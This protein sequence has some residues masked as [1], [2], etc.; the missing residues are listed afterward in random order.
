MLYLLICILVGVMT[1]QMLRF[2]QHGKHS[3]AAVGVLA[4]FFAAVYS[5]VAFVGHKASWSAI[6]S[7]PVLFWA[8]ISGLFGFTSMILVL[9]C[10]RRAGVGVSMTISSLSIVLVSI[11]AWQAWDDQ[12][13]GL[14][15]L[16]LLLVV[17][18]VMLMRP[19]AAGSMRPA[20][21]PL[22]LLLLLCCS[23]AITN[24]SHKAV[25]VYSP[26][27]YELAYQLIRFT[28]GS[29][30]SCLLLAWKW[31]PPTRRDIGVSAAVGL[32]FA[33][34]QIATLRALNNLDAT[35]FYPIV[36]TGPIALNVIIASQLWRERLHR[37][38]IA[39]V[40]VTMIVVLLM[41]GAAAKW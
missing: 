36:G 11:I 18:A 15:W 35:I 14:Q 6:G 5:L 30:A 40:V 3:P 29:L 13:V 41:S 2:S 17:P 10:I 31:R 24:L 37:R 32:C 1:P 22:V 27:D 26:K 25:G 8:V 21:Q 34:A 16:A 19:S 9:A 39:G 4:Y 23:G 12:I 20:G 38:Q 28:T 7:T 33:S